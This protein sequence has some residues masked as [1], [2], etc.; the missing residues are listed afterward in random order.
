M[1]SYLQYRRIRKQLEKQH[2]VKRDMPD[3]VRTRE[4][5]F[6]F[7]DGQIQREHPVPDDDEPARRRREEHGHRTL[8]SGPALHPRHTAR[9]HLEHDGDIELADLRPEIEGEPH[10]INTRDTL[11]DTP[12][13][14]VTG[15]ETRT[16]N[17]RTGVSHDAGG[18]SEQKDKR[19]IVTYEGDCDP[20]DPHNW[21]LLSRIR[22][23]LILSLITAIILWSSTND[24]A[25]LTTTLKV[26]S[27]SFTLEALVIG[28]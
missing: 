21:S 20:M 2:V 12:D 3:D 25:A 24:A 19:V 8:I 15:V 10:T 6:S 23:T 22:S 5:R 9:Q 16:A 4:D 26:Y 11:G 27:V 13:M 17:T 14:M 1:Q 7:H 18:D 28:M